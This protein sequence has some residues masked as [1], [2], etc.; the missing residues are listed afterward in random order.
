MAKRA[1]NEENASCADANDSMKGDLV[2]LTKNR[3]DGILDSI[4][5]RS[6]YFP[7]HLICTIVLQDSGHRV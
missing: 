5:G 7:R 6:D 4:E 3:T 2:A 1:G